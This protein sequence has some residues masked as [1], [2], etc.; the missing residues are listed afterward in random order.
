MPPGSHEQGGVPLRVTWPSRREIGRT[1]LVG[2]L[3]GGA[4]L[5][6]GTRVAMRGVA[7]VEGRVPVWT[8]RGTL[9]VVGMGAAFGLLF[10][11]VWALIARWIPGNRL[12]R[13]LLFGAL[14]AVI[15]SPGLTPQRLST[16]ALFGPWFVAFGV[17]L[18]FMARCS[19]REA[20]ATEQ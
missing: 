4:F 11:L 5:G 16:F 14:C 18:S 9:T 17:A 15:A 20:R 1:L 8:F 10:T 7:L 3:A 13:G 19:P 6:A 2:A 12:V